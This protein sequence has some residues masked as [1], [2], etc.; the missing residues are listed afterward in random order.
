MKKRWSEVQEG[1]KFPDGSQVTKVHPIYSAPCYAVK[2]NEEC[3]LSEEHLLLINTSLCTCEIKEWLLENLDGYAIPT[4]SERHA[5]VDDLEPLLNAQTLNHDEITDLF[6]SL[7]LYRGNGVCFLGDHIGASKE[8][9]GM[10]LKNV[11]DIPMQADPAHVEG[12]VYWLPVKLIFALFQKGERLL[13]IRN[14]GAPILVVDVRYVGVQQVRCVEVTGH[15]FETAGFIHHNS[16]TLRNV[17]LHCLTHGFEIAIAL[18][19]LKMTEFEA[20]KGVKN[21]VAVANSVREAV[22]ILRIQ[23]ECMYAHNFRVFRVL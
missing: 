1:D 22:E 9:L 17:I 21:V 2:N 13:A 14:V 19:D 4:L 10:H 12:D 15:R 7:G 8:I 3:V 20:Y 16:V 11:E 6:A 5:Y 23:R 18:V